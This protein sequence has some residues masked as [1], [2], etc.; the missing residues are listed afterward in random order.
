MQLPLEIVLTD[1]G[2]GAD[3]KMIAGSIADEPAS[4]AD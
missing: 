2:G 4:L 3:T 1:A